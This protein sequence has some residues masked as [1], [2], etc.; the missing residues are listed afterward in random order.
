MSTDLKRVSAYVTES[1]KAEFSGRAKLAGYTE[2]ML[3]AFIVRQ[4]LKNQSAEL[5]TNQPHDQGLKS[6]RVTVR[7]R[8]KHYGKLLELSS[9][10]G[11]KPSSYLSNLFVVHSTQS[12]VFSKAELAAV[13]EAAKELAALGRNVN[14]IAKAINITDEEI[15]QVKKLELQELSAQ[16]NAIRAGLKDMLRANL[17]SWGVKDNG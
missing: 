1:E 14:Q 9:A 17:D 8:P 12:P 10:R 5:P 4:F 13:R 15:Y 6:D 7:F 2:S 3:L 16:L 11:M